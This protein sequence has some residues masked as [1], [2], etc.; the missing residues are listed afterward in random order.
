M[1]YPNIRLFFQLLI[2][3]HLWLFQSSIAFSQVSEN[4]ISKAEVWAD[5][6]YQSLTLEEKIAQLFF[7]RANQSGEPY[8]EEVGKYIKNYNIGGVV[9]FRAD[10][11]SQALKTNEWNRLA[12]TPLFIAIDAEWGLGMR[13]S[14][15]INYPV[16]DDTRCH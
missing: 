8:I 1:R 13:L 11:I 14:N 16:T 9:F 3:I 2:T 5:S 15:T 10:P 7:A 6:V 4:E 12:K